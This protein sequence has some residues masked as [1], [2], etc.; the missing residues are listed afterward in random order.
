MF[1]K[2]WIAYLLQTQILYFIFYIFAELCLKYQ[3]CTLSGCKDIGIRKFVL[4]AKTHFLSGFFLFKE[5]QKWLSY[6]ETH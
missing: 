2:K 3:I 1:C 5:K 4:V 6:S